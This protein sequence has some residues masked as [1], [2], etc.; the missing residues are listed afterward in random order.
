MIVL[1]R[2]QLSKLINEGDGYSWYDY[3]FNQCFIFYSVEKVMKEIACAKQKAIKIRKELEEVGLWQMVDQGK[4]KPTKIFVKE[5]IES[6]HKSK[7]LRY[8]AKPKKEVK[9]PLLENIKNVVEE[10]KLKAVEEN[11]GIMS[12]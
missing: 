8:M 6:Q 1:N 2:V 12:Y 9:P 11:Y 5:I 4:N 10:D 3:K 7:A